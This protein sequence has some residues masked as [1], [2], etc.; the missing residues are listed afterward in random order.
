[1]W[2]KIINFFIN[3]KAKHQLEESLTSVKSLVNGKHKKI[4]VYLTIG[5]VVFISFFFIFFNNQTPPPVIKKS[6]NPI[7]V[8]SQGDDLQHWTVQSGETLNSLK[9]QL[10][11]QE[12]NALE[13]K[14]QINELNTII[15]KQ[16]QQM[17]ELQEWFDK[18]SK[19]TN[20]NMAQFREQVS[21][22]LQRQE[23]QANK[24]A[25]SLQN[26]NDN[27][28]D[29][30]K[31]TSMGNDSSDQL[32]VFAPPVE[33]AS[34]QNQP[35]IKNPYHGYLP[36]GSFFKA[37]LLNGIT[38]PTGTV[39]V[40]NPVPIIMKVMTDAILPNDKYRYQLKGCFIMGTGYG[41]VSSERVQVRTAQLSCIKNDGTAAVIAEFKGFVVDSDGIADLRGKLENRQGSKVAMATLAG[42]A[43]GIGQMF[44]NA[45]GTTV[46]SPSGT[47]ISMDTNQ[48]LSAAGF[49]GVGTAADTVSKFYVKQA[50]QIFP[51]IV[52]QTGRN[53][54]INLTEGVTLHW[55]NIRDRFIPSEKS[56]TTS[57][58][59]N[60]KNSQISS[61][62]T[63]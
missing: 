47:G 39:G 13:S 38:A 40:D 51:V 9:E 10:Q 15:E 25:E 56:Q 52:V 53:V 11:T 33:K 1:M 22:E 60:N 20:A 21:S 29:Q 42:F 23:T 5:I 59:T 27:S 24:L 41:S 4:T 61:G 46:V 45:Q 44:G 6:D 37:T 36:V 55:T 31:E 12:K 18:Q 16:K 63:A 57:I 17:A 14:K 30:N 62:K 3:I 34:T 58:V 54:T 49:N 50:E 43:Q 19:E 28:S 26:S 35:L 48:K 8:I 2:N 32:E 7:S